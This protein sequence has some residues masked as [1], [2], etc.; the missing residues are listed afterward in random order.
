ML[1]NYPGTFST[2]SEK[3]HYCHLLVTRRLSSITLQD[4]HKG[5]AAPGN[6]NNTP[7]PTGGVTVSHYPCGRQIMLLQV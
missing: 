4:R 5:R 3:Y 1:N 2:H 7:L 6:Y